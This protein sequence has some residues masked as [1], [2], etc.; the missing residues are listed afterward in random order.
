M[1]K[2][3]KLSSFV[4]VFFFSDFPVKQG[5]KASAV[6]QALRNKTCSL[7]TRESGWQPAGKVNNS[8]D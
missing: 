1:H 8:I 2:S 3:G 6:K 5:G 4:L 7:T